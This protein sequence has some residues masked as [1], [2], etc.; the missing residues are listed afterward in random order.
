MQLAVQCETE[1]SERE[2]QS[3]Q[4][5][6]SNRILFSPRPRL[7]RLI[8]VFVICLCRIAFAYGFGLGIGIDFTFTKI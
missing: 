6:K 1:R 4:I 2:Q 8:R 5:T 7:D 3:Q